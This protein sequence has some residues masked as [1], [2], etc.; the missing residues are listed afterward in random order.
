LTEKT[1]FVLHKHFART[2]HFDLR[3][4]IGKVLKSWAVPKGAPKK[5]G[6]KHLAI[7]VDD[8]PLSYAHFE[9]VIPEGQYGSGR[10]LIADEGTC[11]NLKSSSFQT[12]LK[13]GVLEFQLQGKRLK[14][15][16]ALVHFRMGNWLWIKVRTK[17]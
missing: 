5:I 12:C 3:L 15:S 9:G 14:G 8:H 7:L 17:R 13:K 2:L 10:V 4:Q 6:T 16:Y 1:C 11:T